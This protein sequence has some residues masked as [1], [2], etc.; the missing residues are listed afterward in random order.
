MIMANDQV[1]VF[2]NTIE[3]NQTAGLS[4]VSYLITDKPFQDE[5]YDPF[6]EA[7]SVHDNRFAANGGKPA[8]KLGG[9]LGQVL[10]T[11]LPDILYDGVVDPKKQVDG[12]LPDPLALHIHNNGEAGFANFD[13]PALK[14]SAAEPGK[15]PA[16]KI[17]RDPKAYGGALPALGAVSIEGLK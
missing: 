17:I 14:A 10:G 7:I 9:L 3:Q 12:K 1:E 4:I 16:P 13:A 8:G 6:C 5:K 11:P 15:G 2:D